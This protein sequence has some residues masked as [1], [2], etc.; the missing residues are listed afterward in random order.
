MRPR[1]R[2]R[3]RGRA[4]Q[5][6]ER[7]RARVDDERHAPRVERAVVERVEAQL[8]LQLPPLAR[9]DV[10]LLQLPAPVRPPPPGRGR[11]GGCDRHVG[12]R[13]V[14]VHAPPATAE[15][16]PPGERGRVRAGGALDRGAEL[17]G[18]YS[19]SVCGCESVAD[20]RL[21][22]RRAGVAPGSS[23]I[24]DAPR[25]SQCG[26][27]RAQRRRAGQWP[28]WAVAEL[29]RCAFGSTRQSAVDAVGSS[30]AA[31]G[32]GCGGALG[33]PVRRALEA[34]HSRRT[35]SARR[36]LL[37]APR[38]T[39][40]RFTATI[41]S[42]RRGGTYSQLHGSQLHDSQLRFTALGAEGH[43]E[44]QPHRQLGPA[45]RRRRSDDRR[46]VGRPRLRESTRS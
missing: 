14:D 10:A 25:A 3:S 2:A 19:G 42:P 7:A 18:A 28:S 4:R 23:M 5:L 6:A 38:F 29:G 24:H 20:A 11:E 44:G 17:V 40:P 32:Q 21:L 13:P 8:V 9:V 43:G 39:A 45:A 27:R 31:G 16:Q 34:M 26:G 36:D 15:Q 37:T 41:H 35:P 1:V 30:G 12:V 33:H 46:V 22:G